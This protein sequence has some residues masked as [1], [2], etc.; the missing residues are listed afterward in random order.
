MILHI[1]AYS[2]KHILFP[3]IDFINIHFNPSEHVHILCTAEQVI[4][5]QT[6]VLIKNIFTQSKEIS[7]LMQQAQ[8]IIL[9]GIWYDELYNLYHSQKHLLKKTFWVLWSG[10]FSFPDKVSFEKKW[11]F[12]NIHYLITGSGEDYHFVKKHYHARGQYL[13]CTIFYPNNLYQETPMQKMAASDTLNLMVG[14]SADPTNGHMEV[15]ERL[16]HHKDENIAVYT[17]LVYGNAEYAKTVIANGMKIFGDKFH[18]LTEY[19]DL[20]EYLV[21]LSSIDIAIFNHTVQQ[22]TGNTI[23]LLSLGKKVY[24]HPKSNLNDYFKKFSIQVFNTEHIELSPIDS[25]ISQSNQAN[26]KKHFSE[27]VLLETLN[28]IFTKKISDA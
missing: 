2:S 25:V 5:T 22:A 10:E 26:L 17:P 20:D 6:N 14:N 18:P 1:G 15:F 11:L 7:L 3:F 4:P 9:H 8:K 12:Q 27:Q 19:T 24:L 28:D 13:P 21:F 23:S 16:Q